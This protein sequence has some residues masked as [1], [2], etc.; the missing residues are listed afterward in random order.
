MLLCKEET[1]HLMYL[2]IQKAFGKALSQRLGEYCCVDWKLVDICKIKSRNQ[3]IK[4]FSYLTR[5]GIIFI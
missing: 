1:L 5:T 2:N 4:D 3:L